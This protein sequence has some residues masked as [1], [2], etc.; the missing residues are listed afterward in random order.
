MKKH[1]NQNNLLV[2]I[3]IAVLFFALCA[4]VILETFAAAGEL[5][6]RSE[7][8]SAAL[9]DA[10]DVHEQ[11]YAAADA[12]EFLRESGFALEDGVWHREGD[13]YRLE[14]V[15]SEEE[16]GAGIMRNATISALRRDKVFLEI[17]GARYLPGGGL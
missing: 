12:E 6:K 1:K 16:K 4:T 3:V 9:Y 8:E 5:V 7:T 11:L 17:P 15:L 13:G 14:L 2:E 10:R